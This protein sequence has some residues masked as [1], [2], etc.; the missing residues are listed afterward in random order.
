MIVDCVV[1]YIA[2]LQIYSGKIG[3]TRK[4]KQAERMV[5]DLLKNL[6]RSDPN[7]TTDNL[8]TTYANNVFLVVL[9]F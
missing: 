7:I 3:N 2:N 9:R 4:Q 8:F 5:S 1:Q 6:N